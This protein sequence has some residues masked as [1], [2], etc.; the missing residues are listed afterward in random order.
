MRGLRVDFGQLFW[1]LIVIVPVAVLL[2]KQDSGFRLLFSS[3]PGFA[4][5]PL[6]W[7]GALLGLLG[8]LGI[9]VCAYL[10]SEALKAEH[11]TYVDQLSADAVSPL[12]KRINEYIAREYVVVGDLQLPAPDS[13]TSGHDALPIKATLVVATKDEQE[14]IANSWTKRGGIAYEDGRYTDFVVT[15][16]FDKL[17]WR[18]LDN[19]TLQSEYSDDPI[20]IE[21]ALSSSTI[22]TTA[23][24]AKYVVCFGLAS[25]EEGSNAARNDQLAEQ[26]SYNLCTA[27]KNLDLMKRTTA[28][29]IGVSIGQANASTTDPDV[30]TRQRAAVVIAVTETFLDLRAPDIAIAAANLIKVPNVNLTQYAR[31]NKGYRLL[32]DVQK[33]EYVALDKKFDWQDF[34]GDPVIIPASPMLSPKP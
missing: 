26:R 22:R 34:D 15:V 17:S 14:N 24:D 32:E 19:Q 8:G 20:H 3:T 9:L 28:Q 1:A 21:Q 18:K 31:F 4:A 6:A 11:Q 27:V 33:G 23:A 16:L 29:A 5:T 12:Q 7:W 30:A 10:A 25:H 13:A 2:L